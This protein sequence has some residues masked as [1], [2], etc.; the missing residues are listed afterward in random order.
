VKKN[1]NDALLTAV[2][3]GIADKAAYAKAYEKWFGKAP[4]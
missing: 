3:K 2:D 1:G 4:E